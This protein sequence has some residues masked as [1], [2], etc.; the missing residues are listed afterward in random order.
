MHVHVFLYIVHLVWVFK[1]ARKIE[2]FLSIGEM[3]ECIH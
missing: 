2:S 3:D 1:F